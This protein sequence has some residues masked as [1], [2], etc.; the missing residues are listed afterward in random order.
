MVQWDKKNKR[1]KDYEYKL[2]SDI[3]EGKQ[4]FSDLNKKYAK[5]NLI[6]VKKL[7]FDL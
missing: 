4:P 7:G 1:L 2:M 3:S 5:W 6:K